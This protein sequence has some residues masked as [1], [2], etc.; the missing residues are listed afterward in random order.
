MVVQDLERQ[1][2]IRRIVAH[3]AAG[4]LV[5][6][7]KFR[8]RCCRHRICWAVCKRPS[9]QLVQVFFCINSDAPGREVVGV[10]GVPSHSV[11]IF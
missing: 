8:G 7:V 1:S 9:K 2:Q 3:R 10:F 4:L 5:E 6:E 11:S